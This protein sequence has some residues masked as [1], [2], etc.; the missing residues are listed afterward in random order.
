MSH[1]CFH[2]PHA[3][4]LVPL[5]VTPDTLRAD[6]VFLLKTRRG[7]DSDWQY[8]LPVY[9]TPDVQALSRTRAIAGIYVHAMPL[10]SK[11]MRSLPGLPAY[12]V[13]EIELRDGT[14]HNTVPKELIRARRASIGLATEMFAAGLVAGFW[15]PFVGGCLAALST[16]PLRTAY[17]L[18]FKPF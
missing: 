8:L 14:R 6:N 2:Y 4:E 5:G 12:V 17:S 13:L 9:A 15:M 16:H 7:A 10:G 11:A 3:F 18:Y 1:T